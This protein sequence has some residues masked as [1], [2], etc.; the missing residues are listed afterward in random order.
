MKTR[1]AT[2]PS[3][4]TAAI[5]ECRYGFALLMLFSLGINLLVLTS[6]IYMMQVY[7]RVLG[8]GH[9]ETLVFLTVIAG[10]AVLCLGALEMVRGYLLGRMGKWLE[11]RLSPALITASFRGGSQGIAPSAQSLRDLSTLRGFLGGPAVTSLL[12]AP[13]APVFIVI[14]WVLH[15]WLGIVALAS[16]I[17]LFIL[18]V[19]SEI[20]SRKPLQE[21]SKLQ[22]AAQQRIELAMR[23]ADA[24]QAMGMRPGFL[25]RWHDT[26]DR[27]LALQLQ[28]GD[29]NATLVGITKFFRLFVQTMI[30]G[31]GAALVLRTELTAGGMIAGSILLGRALAPVEQAIGA[32][33]AMVSARHAKERLTQVFERVPPE[34]PAMQLPA[35]QG[36]LACE[37]V[38][39]MG[40]GRELPLLRGVS[41]QLNP[42]EALGVI[43][44]SAAGKSVLC[45]AIVGAWRPF[46]GTVRLDGADI[47][48]W[49]PDQLGGYVGYLPQDVE[50][51]AGTVQ[52]NIARLSSHPDPAKVVDAAK[53]AGVHD[54]I[55]SLP[56]GYD[57]EIGEMGAFLSGGQRQRIGLARAF[58][59]KP[60]LIVL[61]EPNASLD[62]DGEDA[63]VEGIGIAKQW[64][65]AVIIVAHQARVLAPVDKVLFMREGVV[66]AFG[67]RDD[68]LRR[69]RPGNQGPGRAKAALTPVA[70]GTAAARN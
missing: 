44:A 49:D 62:G 35:P 7:D 45:K 3:Q 33:K 53:A 14:I 61:D 50:L 40:R 39:V 21:A 28:A 18:A 63:L 58:Y 32:W 70:D 66:E 54:M 1:A 13:W 31:V 5:R 25:D 60:V 47:Y 26:N 20:S 42:G 65:A 8:S 16:A 68:V 23:N 38:V 10:V 29:R 15:P 51:F 22:I 6:P 64:G 55:L 37:G 27:S 52:D 59:D 19:L 12:D 56:K 34:T 69:L 9:I 48:G 11:Q 67:P 46:R 41:F 4:L 24:V 17:I 30:L 36:R 57:T 43:G 2:Q